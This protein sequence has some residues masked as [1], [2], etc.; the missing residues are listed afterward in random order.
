MNLFRRIDKVN[1]LTL[2]PGDRILF[3][4]G[5]VFKGELRFVGVKG[6]PGKPIIVAVILQSTAL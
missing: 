4:A 3:A 5:Q 1:T 6:L 2:Q